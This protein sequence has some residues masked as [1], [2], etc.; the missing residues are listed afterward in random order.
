MG[1]T[2]V[3]AVLQGNQLTVANVGDSRAYLI[4][5]SGIRQ[6]TH[7]HTWVAEQVREGTLTGEEAAGHS[8]RHVITRSLGGQPQV[9]VDI[10][11]ETAQPGDIVLLCSD[12][13]SGQASDEEIRRIVQ[14][15]SPQKA[16]DELIDLANRRGGLDNI[17]AIVIP[18]RPAVGDR[19]VPP[20][21][22]QIISDIRT[23]FLRLPVPK[24]IIVVAAITALLIVGLF[25]GGF[26]VFTQ[27]PVERPLQ[28]GPLRYVVKQGETRE[29]LA[30]YFGVQPDEIVLPVQSGQNLI[31]VLPQYG[32][33]VSGLVKSVDRLVVNDAILLRLT[34][35]SSEYEVVC[36]LKGQRKPTIDPKVVPAKGDIV[37]VFG[38]AE[39]GHRIRAVVVD[40]MK[41]SLFAA[42]WSNWYYAA[43]DE[44]VWLYTSFSE[45]TLGMDTEHPLEQALVRGTWSKGDPA[46]FSYDDDDVY[47]WDGEAYSSAVPVEA[48]KPL[49]DRPEL[50][51]PPAVIPSHP[52][53]N[54][55]LFPSIPPGGMSL[56]QDRSS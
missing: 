37:T 43:E 46:H 22:R 48:R 27:P 8:Y 56:P 55:L 30:I 3:A 36:Q 32:Y 20:A 34:N 51:P 39:G 52:R 29:L 21:P 13:L 2:I 5:R 31:I 26:F 35:S 12:G 11:R 4:E 15:N 25:L 45:F 1:T 28:V 50:K 24:R 47:L 7:D 6:L 42:K 41:S 54:R 9:E 17:T 23:W 40:V 33:Y 38:W 53:R 49:T 16:A 44:P 19:V 10:F 14:A 18:V